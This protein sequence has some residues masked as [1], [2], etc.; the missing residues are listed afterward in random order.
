MIQG[1]SHLPV[2]CLIFSF[3]L[4]QYRLNI[5]HRANLHNFP[6]ELNVTTDNWLRFCICICHQV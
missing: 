5:L 1:G 3:N 2:L 6:S 4:L